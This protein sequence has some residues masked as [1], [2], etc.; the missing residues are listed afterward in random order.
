LTQ[1]VLEAAIDSTAVAFVSA[2]LAATWLFRAA[3][4]FN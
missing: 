2:A 3:V 1:E 4:P